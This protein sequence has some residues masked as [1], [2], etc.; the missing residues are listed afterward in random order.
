MVGQRR[1]L[2]LLSMAGLVLAATFVACGDDKGD[3]RTATVPGSTPAE[4]PATFRA[5]VEL[6]DSRLQ[7]GDVS[8]LTERMVTE[9]VVCR[10]E[11]ITPEV[12]NEYPCDQVGQT[13]DG[14]D[15][16]AWGS[17]GIVL[18][19]DEAVGIIDQLPLDVVDD[20]SDRFGNSSLRVYA[21]NDGEWKTT[22]LTA[23]IERPPE[24]AGTGP[25]RVALAAEW[26]YQDD[27]WLLER[28]TTAWVLA[29]DFLEPSDEV[30][31][32]MFPDWEHF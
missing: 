2:S 5:F 14:F 28:I 7:S 11:D 4:D 1:R 21:I 18:P 15:W 8:L 3:A 9:R 6:V 29:E 17:H 24:F 30:R 12:G 23:I 26:I 25:L 13:Y 10:A 20:A 31:A 19:V 16:G 27:R 32:A 22:V